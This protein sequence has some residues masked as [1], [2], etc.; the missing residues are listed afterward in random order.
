LSVDSPIY[1]LFPETIVLDTTGQAYEHEAVVLTPI[2]NPMRVKNMLKDYN[3]LPYEDQVDNFQYVD[4]KAAITQRHRPPPS[5]R[6]TYGHDSRDNRNNSDRGNSDRG[7]SDRG[8]S[9][10]GNS[11]RGGRGG[12]RTAYQPRPNQSQT[13]TQTTRERTNS[14]SNNSN[15]NSSS[16]S[17]RGGYQPRGGSGVG[18]YRG[19][20]PPSFVGSGDRG[21]GGYQSRG[22]GYQGSNSSSS[23]RGGY[24]NKLPPSISGG[25]SYQPRGGYQPQGG[26]NNR[27]NYQSSNSLPSIEESET[28]S[29][30]SSIRNVRSRPQVPFVPQ[31][32]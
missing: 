18:G 3:L 12:N 21:R 11:D 19:G 4:L 2:V 14:G 15:F 32:E 26:S 1:D 25:G 7:N 24:Q 28:A 29:L 9:D 6:Q 8:N 17:G 31:E 30:P 16:N 13:Q 5:S 20:R 23:G 22:I 10:R 27:G